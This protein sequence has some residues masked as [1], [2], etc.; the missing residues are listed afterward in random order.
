[1]GRAK[2]LLDLAGRPV[3]ER[4]ASALSA[5]GTGRVVIVAAPP[6]LEPQDRGIAALAKR[7]GLEV[8]INPSP[9]RGMLSSILTGLATVQ[10]TPAPPVLICPADLPA[11]S[12]STV[13]AVLA[14][15]DPP[16]VSLAVPTF[17]GRR[18]H[19]LAIGPDLVAEIPTLDPEVGLKQLLERHPDRLREVPVDDFGAVHDVDTPEDY[20]RLL[21]RLAARNE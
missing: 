4:V 5:G 14:A 6:D 16:D 20:E 3:L 8:A 18:G 11:L 17:E 19:P 7:L 21:A 2:V 9:E 13:A 15:L 1:M 12:P 10:T